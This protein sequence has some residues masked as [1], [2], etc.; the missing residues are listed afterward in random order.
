MTLFGREFRQCPK[1]YLSSGEAEEVGSVYLC[2]GGF[3]GSM[4]PSMMFDETAYYWS[5]RNIVMMERNRVE[6]IREARERGRHGS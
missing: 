5:V 1:N 2:E 3:G 6:K 4:L